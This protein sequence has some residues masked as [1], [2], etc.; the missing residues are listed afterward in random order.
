VAWQARIGQ[1]RGSVAVGGGVVYASTWSGFLHA[2]D[3]TTGESIWIQD[4]FGNATASPA[5]TGRSVFVGTD[6]GLAALARQ[7]GAVQWRNPD[8]GGDSSPAIGGGVIYSG[9]NAIAV[10]TGE[11]LWTAPIDSSVSSSPAVA[12]GMVFI[13]DWDGNVHAL[14]AEDGTVLW[15]THVGLIVGGSVAAVDG[16]AY[17]T[18]RGFDGGIFALDARTGAL[19]W[20]VPGYQPSFGDT[21][22]AIAD[23]I[24]YA[25]DG[26][27]TM[28]AVDASTGRA[29]WSTALDWSLSP[30]PAV[31]NGVVYVP[32]LS[33]GQT[34]SLW[35]LDA[36]T[37]DV[38]WQLDRPDWIFSSPVIVD[39]TVYVGSEDTEGVTAYRLPEG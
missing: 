36:L 21:S 12:G 13:G 32:S 37:G 31:A 7:T 23:G 27:G 20:Q 16:Y 29:R 5:I 26:E 24:V 39:G 2:L 3:A 25:G 17:G 28:Y 34:G 14:D 30:S 15:T 6:R 9:N 22:P 4:I 35:A 1:V 8:A 18:A 33:L 11:T 19:I 10:E 38:L